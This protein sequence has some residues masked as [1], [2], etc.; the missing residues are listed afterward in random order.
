MNES[1]LESKRRA[2]IFH[3]KKHG[4]Q[5]ALDPKFSNLPRFKAFFS[6]A[7]QTDITVLRKRPALFVEVFEGTK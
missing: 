5:L 3:G 6:L 2:P 4:K 1:E 7:Q